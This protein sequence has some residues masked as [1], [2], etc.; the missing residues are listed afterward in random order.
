MA[1]K[2]RDKWLPALILA[3]LVH[4]IV[5][6]VFY[7]NSSHNNT[8][9]SSTVKDTQPNHTKE[10]ADR[11][12]KGGITEDNEAAGSAIL[13]KQLNAK[14][15]PHAMMT[16]Q[17]VIEKPLSS[18]ATKATDSDQPETDPITTS[19]S[20]SVTTDAKDTHH[21]LTSKKQVKIIN[22]GNNVIIN[23][24]SIEDSRNNPLTTPTTHPALLDMDAPKVNNL[25][26]LDKNYDKA[27]NETEEVN[28]KLSNAIG[29]IK[30]RN[31]QKIDQQR[32]QQSYAHAV[33]SVKP[34]SNITDS[35]SPSTEPTNRLTDD[36]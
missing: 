4:A 28:E 25:K 35:T 27:K 31:Q 19:T 5:F 20:D 34:A 18:N 21:K 15:M 24:G 12:K 29:E 6:S 14:D 23:S 11:S 1:I 7:W 8:D 16:E 9:A 30:K 32:Q 17:E 36:E 2:T 33:E 26:G 13:G 22:D 10:K 3:L